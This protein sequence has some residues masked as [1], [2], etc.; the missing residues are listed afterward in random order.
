[1]DKKLICFTAT[2]GRGIVRNYITYVIS[3][4]TTEY[5]EVKSVEVK[6]SIN[7]VMKKNL[8]IILPLISRPMLMHSIYEKEIVFRVWY[9]KDDETDYFTKILELMRIEIARMEI[10]LEE[11]KKG[12]MLYQEAFQLRTFRIY[13]T[14]STDFDRECGSDVY[15][16]SMVV[17]AYS[18]SEAKELWM[19]YYRKIG[20]NEIIPSTKFWGCGAT[21]AIKRIVDETSSE[22]VYF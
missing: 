5:Y 1:M 17:K 4:E 8:G 16:H 6:T 14:E 9:I 12:L 19:N 10:A 20:Y 13:Y 18:A 3:G 2:L 15:E 21:H 11:K 7:K 22:V